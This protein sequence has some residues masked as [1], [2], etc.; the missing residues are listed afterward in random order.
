MH[1]ELLAKL[2]QGLSKLQLS[3]TD[4]Q[5]HQ[6]VA[7]IELMAKWNKAY[8]LTSVRNPKDMLTKHILDSLAIAPFIKN[9]RYIDVGT[10]PGLP[11]IP[12]AIAC[13]NATF[14]CLDSLGKRVRFMKQVSFE[15][16]LKNVEPIQSRVEDFQP[17]KS[18]DGVLSRAFASIND[19]LHWCNHLI[20]S[21]GEFLALKGQYPQDELEVIADNIMIV[22][23]HQLEIPF[24]EG[25][26]NLIV[27][28]KH[29]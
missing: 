4:Q 11:G 12:L 22:S 23:T 27:L 13:P 15:L 24:L 8:N 10:G 16:K 29:V 18:Y 14:T 3:L 26:R 17:I 25:E 19:M 2:Q 6:L 7:Y 20:D 21:S 5:C 28:K 9:E 1:D